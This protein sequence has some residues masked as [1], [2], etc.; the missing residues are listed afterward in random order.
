MAAKKT[1]S[2]AAPK[3]QTTTSTAPSIAATVVAS[4][5][6]LT[7]AQRAE[8]LLQY[9][10]EQ[11]QAWAE[12]TQAAA[13]LKDANKWLAT[14]HDVLVKLTPREYQPV[15]LAFLAEHVHKLEVAQATPATGASTPEER[16]ARDGSFLRA[17]AVRRELIEA[18]TQTAGGRETVRRRITEAG[19]A[20]TPNEA[21]SSMA[22]LIK[23]ANEQLRN[24][25]TA[26][27]SSGLTAEFVDTVERARAA[28]EA[29]NN[30][31]A[32]GVIG[33]GDSAETNRL[34]GRVLRE[35]RLAWTGLRNAR[36]RD[37]RI[38]ALV[39]GPALVRAFKLIDAKEP[40]APM[41]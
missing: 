30:A 22:A 14:I 20:R 36:R 39:P 1:K 15:R 13:T 17:T 31:A 32:S 29:A 10:D 41:E 4:W 27:E 5:P 40:P 6:P 12:R 24:S 33:T 26:S 16:T 38:P 23:L 34:E 37:G 7:N 19:P 2:K 18:L 9:S 28:L 11:C 25:P 35:L 3:K 8:L 21:L